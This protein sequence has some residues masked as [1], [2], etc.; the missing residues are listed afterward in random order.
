MMHLILQDEFYR[1]L[2]WLFFTLVLDFIYLFKATKILKYSKQEGHF[3]I[4][5][6]NIWEL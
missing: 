1:L 2:K 5:F 4:D 6:N 3:M